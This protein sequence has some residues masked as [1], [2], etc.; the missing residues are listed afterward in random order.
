MFLSLEGR[1]SWDPVPTGLEVSGALVLSSPLLASPG[2]KPAREGKQHPEL[3]L[4]PKQKEEKKGA[5]LPW[6]VSVPPLSI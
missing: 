1:G 6:Y 5:G 4:C 2:K 3:T